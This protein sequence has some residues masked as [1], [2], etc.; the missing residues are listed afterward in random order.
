MMM[1]LRLLRVRDCFDHLWA[2]HGGALVEMALALPLFLAL[3][4]GAAEFGMASYTA[5]EVENAAMAGVQYGA[6]QAGASGDITG[7]QNAATN[8]AANIT[9]GTTTVSKTCICS[10]GAASTC[11]P[12][13]C[14]GAHIETILTVQTQ[15]TFK[16]G[17]TVPGFPTSFTLYGQAVQKVLQ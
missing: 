17:I 9:L 11:L 12:T 2:E 7:I 3:L 13:D 15:T 5:V 6:S 16:P 8:D 4:L 1:G 14:S 10:N